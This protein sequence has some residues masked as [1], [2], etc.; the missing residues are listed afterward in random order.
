MGCDGGTI[1]KRDELVKTR[2]KP[3]QK[4]KDAENHCKWRLCASSQEELR[5]PIVACELGRMFN[6][7]SVLEILLDKAKAPECGKHLR[8]LKDVKEL[9]LTINPAFK[10]HA[11]MGDGYD[12]IQSAE[13]ICPVLGIEMNGKFKF[14]FIWTCGCVM[15]E[16]SLKEIKTT[17]CHKC[18]KPF[19]N[20]DVIVINP[21]KEELVTM[22]SNMEA[23]RLAAKAKNK[24]VKR[25]AG[26][27]E[28]KTEKGKK[29]KSVQN[30]STN[31]A[32][33]L[34]KLEDPSMAKTKASYS[35]AKDP[36]ASDV[37]KSLFT[38]H[39]KAVNQTKGHWVTYNPF[40][41]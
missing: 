15:S 30:N 39:A 7:E 29:L 17:S 16:R 34:M 19:A 33:K 6:K 5:S 40:Y 3:E 2:K 8:S 20:E 12:D 13:Y 4:D 14:C 37:Y 38:T 32:Q 25:D 18:Q 31:I 24:G 41:N 9:V 1:P 28:K 22:T 26:V 10:K 21:S 27:L 35:V 23:R 36:E 11:N